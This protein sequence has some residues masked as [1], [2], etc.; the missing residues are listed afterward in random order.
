MNNINNEGKVNFVPSLDLPILAFSLGLKLFLNGE[1]YSS[2]V[3]LNLTSIGEKQDS[4]RC[5]TPFTECC[6][7]RDNSNTKNRGNWK[8]PNGK[9]LRNEHKNNIYRSRA[10]SSVLLHRKKNVFYPTGVYTCEIPDSNNITRVLHVHL[11]ANI[12]SGM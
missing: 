1:L 7:R 4:L 6:H 8:F 12:T 11:Y 9:T 2:N 10:S 3:A 5:V